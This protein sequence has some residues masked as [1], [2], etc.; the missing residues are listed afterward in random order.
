M[1]D[2]GY[3]TLQWVGHH[4]LLPRKEYIWVGCGSS[5][6]WKSCSYSNLKMLFVTKFLIIFVSESCSFAKLPNNWRVPIIAS[7]RISW[8]SIR[9]GCFEI[10]SLSSRVWL[11]FLWFQTAVIF[12]YIWTLMVCSKSHDFP[13]SW[14][15][16]STRVTWTKRCLVLLSWVK[17]FL[18]LS[19]Y[20]E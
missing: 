15:I 16:F 20:R 2:A 14:Q 11:D 5:L 12:P 19:L 10:I 9:L 13:G 8:N 3:P 17:W 18:L 4:F 6:H 7:P 1:E